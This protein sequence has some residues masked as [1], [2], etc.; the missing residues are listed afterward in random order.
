MSVPTTYEVFAARAAEMANDLGLTISYPNVSFTA[1]T[2]SGKRLGYVA[3]KFMPNGSSLDG[4]PF[5]GDVTNQGL[6]QIS[7][8]WPSAEGLPAALRCAAK[9]ASWFAAG[10]GTDKD[11][12]RVRVYRAPEIA[13][14]LQ[15]S[16]LIQVPVTVRWQSSLLEPT[17]S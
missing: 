17:G 9:A 5:D 8:Y 13:P 4:L 16:D 7:V 12:T 1:P 15:E 3:L 10:W 6:L 2:R 11:G 14:H